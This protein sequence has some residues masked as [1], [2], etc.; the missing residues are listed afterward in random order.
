MAGGGT[1]EIKYNKVVG[2]IQFNENVQNISQ[3]RAYGIDIENLMYD[4]SGGLSFP[5]QSDQYAMHGAPLILSGTGN[6]VFFP[7]YS[8]PIIQPTMD[9][10]I[11]KW[12]QEI[13]TGYWYSSFDDANPQKII[14]S[15]NLVAS[16]YILSDSDNGYSIIIDNGADPV[17]IVIPDGLRSA[18]QVGF[19]QDGT[20]TVTFSSDN[21]A[22][23]NNAT[24]GLKIKG[25]YDQ[26][27]L[28]KKGGAEIYYLLGNTKP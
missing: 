1:P 14:T 5:Y 11:L 28:E 19:I 23:I 8:F 15:A 13:N 2:R 27:Y 16:Q 12:N 18:F 21:L 22:V 26:V 10:S 9:G 17:E 4:G 24:G 6:I 20:G 3:P 7:G 25:Q